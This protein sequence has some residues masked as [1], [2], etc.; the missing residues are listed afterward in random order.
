MP[1]E[2]HTVPSVRQLYLERKKKVVEVAQLGFYGSLL[3]RLPPP[4]LAPCRSL[5]G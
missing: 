5:D 3:T 4:S 1:A 2:G